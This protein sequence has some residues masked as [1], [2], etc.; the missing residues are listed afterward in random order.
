MISNMSESVIAKLKLM[1]D[2]QF[3]EVEF[4]LD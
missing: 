2:E 4:P 3:A 1:T